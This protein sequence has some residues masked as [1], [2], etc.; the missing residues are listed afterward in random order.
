M[1]PRVKPR[2]TRA[3]EQEAF[4]RAAHEF[5]E[6]QKALGGKTSEVLREIHRDDAANWLDRQ[7][8]PNRMEREAELRAAALARQGLD[9]DF[10]ATVQQH[11]YGP[12]S[13]HSWF[14]DMAAS[15]ADERK[16]DWM[17]APSW[18]GVG[19]ARARLATV[20]PLVERARFEQRTLTT[21]ATAGGDFVPPGPS[22]IAEEFATAVR[23]ASKLS[24]ILPRNP[25]P[26][27]GIFNLTTP[28]ITQGATG[29]V[30][31]T[32]NAAISNQD[33]VE[34]NVVNPVATIAGFVD[35][36]Q[37][38]LDHSEPSIDV[39][40][41]ADLGRAYG[42]MLD[43]QLLAGTGGSGQMLGLTAV[44]GITSSSY[45]DASPTQAEAWPAIAKLYADVSTVVGDSAT[46]IAMHPRRRAWLL[47]WK[48]TATGQASVITWP[49]R[50]FEVPAITTTAGAGTNEDYVLALRVEELP[51]YATDPQ[52]QVAFDTSVS[53]VLTVRFRVYGYAS[54]L[55]TRRPEAIGKLGGTGFGGVSFA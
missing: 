14:R 20:S 8:V 30:Q 35:M 37:Q 34:S 13:E 48:D 47:N 42:A 18:G 19:E 55:F 1:S 10:P 5:A 50:P 53:N 15:L 44:T 23:A 46:A 2:M 38:L 11:A 9:A 21:G 41:A 27:K 28:R 36:S 45:T 22:F 26:E 16:I 43:T 52:F 12:G 54:A 7:K 3:E 29:A 6:E 24:T 51:Y 4:R 39:V 32:Q 33:L 40:L 49:A 31:A 17:P 25:L